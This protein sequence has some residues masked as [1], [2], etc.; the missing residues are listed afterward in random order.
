MALFITP[1]CIVCKKVSKVDLPVEVVMDLKL[2]VAVQN[3][4][5]DA[6]PDER[7]LVLTGTHPECWELIFGEE[8]CG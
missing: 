1:A 8:D 5:P 2:G 3:A 6:T 4:M 7:E